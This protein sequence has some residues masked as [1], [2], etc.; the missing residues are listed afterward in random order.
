MES[1]LSDE[2]SGQHSP[3]APRAHDMV[4]FVGSLCLFRSVRRDLEW[5]EKIALG[6]IDRFNGR[7]HPRV[8]GTRS[9]G[10]ILQ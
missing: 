8:D 5:T 6:V 10:Y 7:V 2:G 4:H 1:E 3:S 9:T